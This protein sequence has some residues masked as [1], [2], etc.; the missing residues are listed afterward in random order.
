MK[1]KTQKSSVMAVPVPE[2][3]IIFALTI[4]KTRF[5][6]DSLGRNYKDKTRNSCSNESFDRQGPN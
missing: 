2:K 3:G 1:M 5:V 4:W 6:F